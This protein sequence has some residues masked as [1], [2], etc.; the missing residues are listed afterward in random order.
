MHISCVRGRSF[1]D[2]AAYGVDPSGDG[3]YINPAFTSAGTKI[4]NSM[5]TRDVD[6]DADI[7]HASE[8]QVPCLYCLV[9]LMPTKQSI[10]PG[11]FDLTDF[12]KDCSVHGTV[13]MVS[14]QEPSNG[15]RIA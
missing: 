10:L 9:E 1:G 13:N 6:A 11:Q 2:F 14:Q 12:L 7:T 5:F 3:D 4:Y 15:D 8:D